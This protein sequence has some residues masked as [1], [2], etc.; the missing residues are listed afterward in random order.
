MKRAIISSLVFLLAFQFYSCKEDLTTPQENIAQNE[1]SL[2]QKE[3]PTKK[4]QNPYSLTGKFHNDVMDSIFLSIQKNSPKIK[5]LKNIVE[6]AQRGFLNFSD[7]KNIYFDD[8]Y[9][10]DSFN[11]RKFQKKEYDKT[12]FLN[13]LSKQGY[14]E[15]QI[16][17]MGR[18]YSYLDTKLPINVLRDSI[19]KFNIQVINSLGEKDAAPI[20]HSSSI[21]ISSA[22]YHNKHIKDW[23][24]LLNNLPLEGKK[25]KTLYK[26]TA[27]ALPIDWGAIAH[28]DFVAGAA[29]LVG[30]LL[31]N[32]GYGL[33]VSLT[34]AAASAGELIWQLLVII[35]EM[36]GQL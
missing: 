25:N 8:N 30:C 3:D 1:N 6:S 2:L 29:A 28:A 20:L 36:I 32:V 9:F 15:N 4:Y 31:A 14:S 10:E 13:N 19:K 23:Y 21:L 12:Y 33:C 5:N 27:E 18:L 24:I 22:E 7:S 11:K 17:Y 34:A 35:Y 16:P 26:E